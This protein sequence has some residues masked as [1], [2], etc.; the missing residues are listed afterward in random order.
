MRGA[1]DGD[2]TAAETSRTSRPPPGVSVIVVTWNTRAALRRCLTAITGRAAEI[3]VVDNGSGD[4]TAEMVAA[5]YPEVIL[6]ALPENLGFGAGVNRGARAARGEALLLL[7]PDTEPASGA[8]DALAR[9]LGETPRCGAA[10]A[11]LVSANGEPQAGFAVRRFPTLA[12]WA[13]DLLLVDQVWPGNPITRRYLALD[14]HPEA[15]AT[16]DQPAAAALMVR[17]RAFDAI[18]GMDET[19]VPAWFE[20]VDL[21][22]RLHDAGWDIAYVPAAVIRHEGGL[23]MR[24]LGPRFQSIWYAN[25]LRYARKHESPATVAALRALIVVGMAMRIGVAALRLDADDVRA[26]GRALAVGLR[27]R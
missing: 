26:Y 4:G 16:V 22:R 2:G 9:H 24:A 25:M 12:S 10:G 5:D 14:L 21:C 7:N 23:A 13:I 15:T 20:D 8:I 18:G 17:R 6:V 11:R 19:F 27:G 1:M 3:I